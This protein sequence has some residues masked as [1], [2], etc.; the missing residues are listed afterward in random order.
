MYFLVVEW[1]GGTLT[2][3]NVL[4]IAILQYR[5]GRTTGILQLFLLINLGTRTE[6]QKQQVMQLIPLQSMVWNIKSD[7]VFIW[8]STAVSIFVIKFI[9]KC[10][11]L[12]LPLFMEPDPFSFLPESLKVEIKT[13]QSFSISGFGL[14]NILVVMVTDMYLYVGW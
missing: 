14:N 3:V 2:F 12:L 8:S 11:A 4:Q 7:F 6:A 1:Q 9:T 13:W 10:I 5:M